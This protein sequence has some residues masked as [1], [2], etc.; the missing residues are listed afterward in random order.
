MA[1]KTFIELVNEDRDLEEEILETPFEIL[2]DAV[3]LQ[4]GT[5]VKKTVAAPIRVAK[6]VLDWFDF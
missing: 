4:L 5:A 2:E 3:D 6:N 1:K